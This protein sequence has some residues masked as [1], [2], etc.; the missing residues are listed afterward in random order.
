MKENW[1]VLLQI[2]II[3]LL[4]VNIVLLVKKSNTTVHIHVNNEEEYESQK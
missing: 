1:R 4:T 3:V 2:A